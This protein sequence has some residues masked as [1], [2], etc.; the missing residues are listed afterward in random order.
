MSMRRMAVLLVGLLL[1]AMF[2]NAASR[3]NTMQIK[4]LDSQTR[5]VSLDDNGVPK[6]CDQLTFDAYCRSTRAPQMVHTLLVQEGNDPPFRIACTQESKYSKCTPLPRGEN[7]EAKRDK[8][9]VTVYYID[10]NGKARSQLYTLVDSGGKA[11]PPATGATVAAQ[12]APPAA[13]QQ[14]SPSAAPAVA[15]IRSSPAAAPS[16][17]PAQSAGP[18]KVRCNFS[19]TPA[20]AEITVDWRY[21]GNTPSEIGLGTGTHIVVISMPGFAEWKRELTIAA[22]SVV[23]VTATLQKAQP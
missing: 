22:D 3:K 17:V 1:V 8:H 21:V 12:T 19:S 16:T 2:A 4:V 10:G 7:F 18:Q 9:G 15:P 20:G 23:N 6:N 5:S 13:P 11:A 14:N